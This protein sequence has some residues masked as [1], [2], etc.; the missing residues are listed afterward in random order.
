MN[1]SPDKTCV[2]CG[3]TE[4]DMPPSTKW[5]TGKTAEGEAVGTLIC[6]QCYKRMCLDGLKEYVE[7]DNGGK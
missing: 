2:M 3:R 5:Y 4:W 7:G 6:G 1:I